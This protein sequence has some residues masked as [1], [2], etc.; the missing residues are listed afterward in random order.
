[1]APNVSPKICTFG[2]TKGLNRTNANKFLIDLIRKAK[3]PQ[4]QC[5]RAFWTWRSGWD[6]NPRA[7]ADKRFSR[8]PR[9][10]HFDTSPDNSCLI[11]FDKTKHVSQTA[12]RAS[13]FR[14]NVS[15]SSN[16]LNLTTATMI[17][18]FLYTVC[19]DIFR[20]IFLKQEPGW[21]SGPIHGVRP[22]Y[23]RS[24]PRYRSWPHYPY[25]GSAGA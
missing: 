23:T 18:P 11:V 22:S 10:D 3:G 7:L 19:Q 25:T 12:L 15:R 8:P 1:M 5:L 13:S 24:S 20:F 4:T 21:H 9:Y 6:S 17:I 16:A 14:K 2:A